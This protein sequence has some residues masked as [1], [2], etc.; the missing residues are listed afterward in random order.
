MADV[1]AAAITPSSAAMV[2]FAVNGERVEL[3]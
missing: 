3:R 2:I 1:A